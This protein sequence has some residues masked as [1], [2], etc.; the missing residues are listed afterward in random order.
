[1]LLVVVLLVVVLLILLLLLLALLVLPLLL[2]LL[3]LLLLVLLLL[4][5][6]ILLLLVLLLILHLCSYLTYLFGKRP[7]F[8][9][10]RCHFLFISLVV[11]ESVEKIQ[12][13]SKSD[14]YNGCFT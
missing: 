4:I 14:K 9:I 11:F 1:M 8:Y 13:S 12:V 6:L 3:I 5:L 7:G 10:L 2:M